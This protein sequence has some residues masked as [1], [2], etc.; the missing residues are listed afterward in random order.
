MATG[1]QIRKLKTA[2][3]LRVNPL[4]M[5]GFLLL[6]MVSLGS[7]GLIAQ[8][9]AEISTTVSEDYATPDTWPILRTGDTGEAVRQLQAELNRIGV[10]K[11]SPDGIYDAKTETAVRTFQQN[12]GLATDGIVG[13]QTWQALALAQS[14]TTVFEPQAFTGEHALDFTPLTFSQPPPPPSPFWLMLMPL[15]PLIGGALTYLQ[16]RLSGRKPI[17]GLPSKPAS[18]RPRPNRHPRR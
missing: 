7:P 12:R 10:F 14:P 16:R 1:W 9:S 11:A 13:V 8:E 6:G 4:G 17:P 5:T 18:H 15:V 2:I 3:A